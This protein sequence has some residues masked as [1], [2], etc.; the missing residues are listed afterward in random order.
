MPGRIRASPSFGRH[1]LSRFY[2]VQ[3]AAPASKRQF[4]SDVLP[5]PMAQSADDPVWGPCRGA[6]GVRRLGALRHREMEQTCGGRECRTTFCL[7]VPGAAL[8]AQEANVLVENQSG[9]F[10]GGMESTGP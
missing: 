3:V 7:G 5:Q 8:R 1:R 6:H 2:P 4:L 9:V 10:A